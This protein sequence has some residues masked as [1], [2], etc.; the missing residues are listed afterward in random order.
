MFHQPFLFAHSF[1]A[2]NGKGVLARAI[3]GREL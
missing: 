1:I 3:A 2:Y